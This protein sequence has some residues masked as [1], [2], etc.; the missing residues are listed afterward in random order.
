M[1]ISASYFGRTASIVAEKNPKNADER[2]ATHLVVFASFIAIL[3][4]F[5]VIFSSYELIQGIR[6]V[7]IKCVKGSQLLRDFR[8]KKCSKVK[9]AIAQSLG[10]TVILL[11]LLLCGL[12]KLGSSV[13][14]ELYVLLIL[15]SLFK[16][17]KREKQA[18][19]KNDIASNYREA[20]S[21]NNEATTVN[22]TCENLIGSEQM[23]QETLSKPK[24]FSALNYE[25]QNMKP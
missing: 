8:Q 10:F 16:K 14:I 6:Q 19:T 1:V 20:F 9:P 21:Q 7:R 11:S 2:E 13:A 5:W 23:N 12:P 18:R 15:Y 4:S 24:R 25:L 22:I 17:L 3:I